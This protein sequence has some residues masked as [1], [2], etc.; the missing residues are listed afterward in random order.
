MDSQSKGKSSG[1]NPISAQTAIPRWAGKYN[2]RFLGLPANV[3][4]MQ[5]FG[6]IDRNS[7]DGNEMDVSEDLRA[8]ESLT[9]SNVTYGI[10][11]TYGMKIRSLFLTPD[12]RPSLCIHEVRR[13]GS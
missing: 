11:G 10:D 6:L 5:E 13:Y 1:K 9:G 2:G 4:L 3:T 7:F 8:G 12:P